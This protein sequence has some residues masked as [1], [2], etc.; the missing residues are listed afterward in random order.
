M[1]TT[2][3]RPPARQ[4]KVTVIPADAKKP[5]D[6]KAPAVAEQTEEQRIA[7]RAEAA[8]VAHE[9][10]G[11]RITLDGVTIF[12]PDDAR[13]DFELLAA[14]AQMDDAHARGSDKV[15]V[16]FPEVLRRLTGEAGWRTVMNGLRG[17]NGRVKVER[18]VDFLN[19]VLYILKLGDDEE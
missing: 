16:Y 18:A 1:T 17:E 9:D 7:D 3:R 2:T 13:D 6:R 4:P 12:V 15:L 19:T 8:T 10:D 11:I 5:E 14:I